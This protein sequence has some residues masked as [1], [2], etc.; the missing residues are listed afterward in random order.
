MF[1]RF[2]TIFLLH[3]FAVECSYNTIKSKYVADESI[4][5][6]MSGIITECYIACEL[7]SECYEVGLSPEIMTTGFGNCFFLKKSK[8]VISGKITEIQTI[9]KVSFYFTSFVTQILLSLNVSQTI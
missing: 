2:T 9:T 5:H 1:I 3:I 4:I 6:T 7:H 8:G